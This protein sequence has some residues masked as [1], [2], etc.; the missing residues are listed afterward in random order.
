MGSRVAQNQNW[1]LRSHGHL[2]AIYMHTIW[3]TEYLKQC[4]GSD[5]QTIEQTFQ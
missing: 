5:S 3:R 2:I 4:K 1:E